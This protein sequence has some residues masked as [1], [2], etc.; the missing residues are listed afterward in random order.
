MRISNIGKLGVAFFTSAIL[1]AIPESSLEQNKPAQTNQS[2]SQPAP[3][4]HADHGTPPPPANPSQK[5]N[6]QRAAEVSTTMNLQGDTNELIDPICNACQGVTANVWVHSHAPAGVNEPLQLHAG[7]LSNAGGEVANV[8]IAIEPFDPQKTEASAKFP[9]SV[10]RGDVVYFRVKV[11]GVLS[12][13]K[14]KTDIFNADKIVGSVEFDLPT[15]PFNVKLDTGDTNL[16]SITLTR[17]EKN[18]LL[19]KNDDSIGYPIKWEFIAGGDTSPVPGS[20]K[21]PANG[22]IALEV[23]PSAEW[24]KEAG[25]EPCLYPLQLVEDYLRLPC[26]LRLLFKDKETDGLLK[27]RLYSPE[28]QKDEGAPTKVI[29]IKTNLAYY[30]PAKKAFWGYILVLILLFL[31]ALLSLYINYK[32]PDEQIRADLKKQLAQIG[33]NIEDLSMRLASRL[34]VLAG[35]GRRLLE[36]RLKRLDWRTPEFEKE[37]AEIVDGAAKLSSRVDLLRLMGRLRESYESLFTLDVPPTILDNIENSFEQIANLLDDFQVSDTD[38]QDAQTRLT[39]LRKKIATWSQIDAAVA[40]QISASLQSLYRDLTQPPTPPPAVPP[41]PTAPVPPV[42]PSPGAPPAQTSTP[43]GQAPAPLLASSP[44]FQTL[45]AQFASVV[46]A[47]ECSPPNPGDITAN[48]YYRLDCLAFRG[49]LLRRYA[50]LVDGRNPKQDSPLLTRQ[51]ELFVLIKSESWY[52]LRKARR[53][54]DEMSEE[55]YGEDIRREI[56]GNRVDIRLDRNRIHAYEAVQ[57][58]LKFHSEKCDSA[59]A[60]DE[61]SCTW[62]FGHGPFPDK[63]VGPEGFLEEQGWEVAHY[64]PLS[65]S[66]VVAARFRHEE[67]GDLRDANG[68]FIGPKKPVDV[69]IPADERVFTGS[70][71]WAQRLW[72]RYATNGPAILRLFLALIPAILGLVAGAKDEF[73]K[74]DFYLA[75]GAIFL[76]GFGSDTVKNLLSQKPKS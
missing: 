5:A 20:G 22:Q 56:E 6:S 9:A 32:F 7:L 50:L 25:V 1:L 24:F 38:L 34:R 8:R 21:I 71:I 61:W 53:L 58:Y 43:P 70:F 73:L 13:G 67:A 54:V 29:R 60:R 63:R 64:F 31:G 10:K 41:A 18:R 46:R 23:E 44:T 17:N 69:G 65:M 4:E 45:S 37:R 74:M 42:P 15:V 26:N 75:L 49:N 12:A 28:C 47:L 30:G 36:L 11:T 27:L 19:L 40:G 51:E 68:A 76:L 3:Q 57:F 48:D 35:V 59:S 66:Y 2:H 52:G 33:Q 16:S 55:V 39:D 14:W 62:N 72:A